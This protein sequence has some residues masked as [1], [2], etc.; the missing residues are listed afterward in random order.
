MNIHWMFD[1]R[2]VSL[3]FDGAISPLGNSVYYYAPLALTSK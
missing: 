1:E 3:Y 2:C